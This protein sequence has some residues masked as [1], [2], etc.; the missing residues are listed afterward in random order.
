V[1]AEERRELTDSTIFIGAAAGG[2]LLARILGGQF[3]GR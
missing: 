3:K 2:Q 1:A